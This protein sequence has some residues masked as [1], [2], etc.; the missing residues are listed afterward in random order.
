MAALLRLLLA[1][2]TVAVATAQFACPIGQ[3]YDNYQCS[4]C[5]AG[6]SCPGGRH[7]A[8]Y[9]S[10]CP[11]GK[12]LTDTDSQV[13]GGGNI[14]SCETCPSGCTCPGGSEPPVCSCPAGQYNSRDGCTNCA[15]GCTCA[16]GSAMPVC[17][18]V[19]N[20]CS[21][22]EVYNATLRTCVQCPRNPVTACF[23][24]QAD[25]YSIAIVCGP[26]EYL[27]R[28]GGICVPKRT[29]CPGGSYLVDGICYSCEE[30]EANHN[31]ACP[32][33]TAGFVQCPTGQHADEDFT[34]CVNNDVTCPPGKYLF[35]GRYCRKCW[36]ASACPGGNSTNEVNCQGSDVANLDN[37]ACVA[38]PTTCPAGYFLNGNCYACQYNTG[39]Q[40][41]ND[42]S[43][44]RQ[45]RYC[46]GGTGGPSSPV[47]CGVRVPK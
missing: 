19:P 46:P 43:F 8:I 22:G 15:Y 29:T 5:P 4:A 6:C 1:A 18:S 16:G 25:T 13:T 27:P 17:T 9:C 11:A 36:H 2:A 44:T 26:N 21:R 23:G 37:T 33:G 14:L 31:F 30:M 47:D 42:Q 32:G 20:Y 39:P 10:S 34:T 45:N 41:P 28:Y 38:P 24:G 7:P 40:L 35:E 3:A 12:Y